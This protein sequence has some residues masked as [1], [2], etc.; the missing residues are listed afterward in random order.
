MLE[1]ECLAVTGPTGAAAG[2][3]NGVWGSAN[4]AE[5]SR[6]F[7]G[8]LQT[9]LL[10]LDALERWGEVIHTTDI[11]I[12]G[13][14]VLRPFSSGLCAGNTSGKVYDLR[15]GRAQIPLSTSL[16][17][18]FTRFFPGCT[19]RLFVASQTG[20]FQSIQ[21]GSPS[22]SPDDL[23]QLWLTYD[24]VVA[25]DI[26][27]SG[28]CAIFGTEN[29]QM[30]L[31]VRDINMC[32]FNVNPMPTEFASPLA[33]SL[34]VTNGLGTS[35]PPA[36]AFWDD[37]NLTT[38]QP[39]YQGNTLAML[40][41]AAA[42]A[43]GLQLLAASLHQPAATSSDKLSTP[44]LVELVE[45][46][47]AEAANEAVLVA[48]KP[49]EYDDYRFSSAS[50]PFAFQPPPIETENTTGANGSESTSYRSPRKEDQMT[51]SDWPEDLCPVRP[52][53]ESSRIKV[54]HISIMLPVDPELI[55]SANRKRAVR[56][57]AHWGTVWHPYPPLGQDDSNLDDEDSLGRFV[58]VP[59]V[60]ESQA[61]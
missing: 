28:N 43:V 53:R 41:R 25:M 48:Y 19:D 44:E 61:T 55:V 24:R 40:G 17:P 36:Y 12:G 46:K 5:F 38:G 58:D 27:H 14:V 15:S 3:V 47:K 49:V 29:G 23:G 26:S 31:Y 7:L 39:G 30:Q 11:G 18:C 57:P 56:K 21:W 42:E 37:P 6:I 54:D 20:A 35:V 4:E 22:F 32:Q 2:V 34:L 16:D 60:L 50:V 52:R 1:L 33:E 13:S 8:G 9:S 10:E 45:R 59:R 51:S